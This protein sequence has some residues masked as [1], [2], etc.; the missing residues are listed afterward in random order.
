MGVDASLSQIT[1]DQGAVTLRGRTVPSRS[2]NC[3]VDNLSRAQP[4]MT[5]RER[6]R[7]IA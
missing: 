1:P 4:A 2:G 7:T 5:M 6:L 3:D